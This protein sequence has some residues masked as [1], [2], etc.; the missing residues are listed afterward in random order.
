MSRPMPTGLPL[1][2]TDLGIY[3]NK[4]SSPPPAAQ[5]QPGMERQLGSKMFYQREL[6]YTPPQ[7]QAPYP[8]GGMIWDPIKN[9]YIR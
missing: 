8:R 7:K 9:A 5:M 6:G 2:D 4:Y 3:P 1:G